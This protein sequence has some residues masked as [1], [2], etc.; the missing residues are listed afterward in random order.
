M[1][2]DGRKEL[3]FSELSRFFS[4]Y[5]F[6]RAKLSLLEGD[7]NL[8]GDLEYLEKIGV[9][10]LERPGGSRDFSS[11]KFAVK[12]TEE[13]DKISKIVEDSSVIT[14][15][16]LLEVYKTKIDDAMSMYFADLGISERP[17]QNPGL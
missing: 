9:I 3:P 13:I 11:I 6:R 14:G 17:A 8:L 5:L 12:D 2:K 4:D 15:I 7:A 16:E 10:S 1:L